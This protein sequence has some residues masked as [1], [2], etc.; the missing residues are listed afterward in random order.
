VIGCAIIEAHKNYP[1]GIPQL[2][3]DLQEE[4]NDI[5]NLR[6]DNVRAALNPRWLVR[7]GSG[8]DARGL[9]RNV[10]SGVTYANNIGTD[11]KEIRAQDV[12]RSAYEEQNRL[13]LDIDGVV[14]TFNGSSVQANREV[15]K[16]VGGMNLLNSDASRLEE[17]L[18]RTVSETWVEHVM[19]QFVKLEA[20]Y[21]SDD[22]IL[23]VVA[24]T[25]KAPLQLVLKALSQP[26]NVNVNVGFNATNPQKRIDKLSIGLATISAYSPVTAQKLDPLELVKEVFGTLG[27]KDGLRFFPALKDGTDDPRI[28]QL[29]SQIQQLQQ[30]LDGKTVEAKAKVDV[31]NIN[32][33]AKLGTAKMQQDVKALEIQLDAAHANLQ[34]QI[35][36]I[37]VQLRMEE[38]V[39][40]RKE[41][42][43]AREALSHEIQ[44]SDR[45]FALEIA[46]LKQADEHHKRD[47]AA[48][49][50][51]GAGKPGAPASPKA[52]PAPPTGGSD[53]AGTIMRDRYGSV[54]GMT[55][56]AS[57]P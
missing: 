4:A 51:S 16:T 57:A 38:S 9:I 37:D 8:V 1:G 3:E 22:K 30:A 55:D 13:D 54:P 29:E 35:D 15:G 56:G 32:A 18:I 33:Q 21:E 50:A 53:M 19:S 49:A 40:K 46:K 36:Q 44:D 10:P 39:N 42:Y 12:T 7:R 23:Q 27:Y 45:Q 52:L 25:V 14:G 34:S 48:K 43:L 20:A 47:S 41:L 17:Y 11:V 31:A 5:A 2:I 26:V 28:A 24:D 6:I